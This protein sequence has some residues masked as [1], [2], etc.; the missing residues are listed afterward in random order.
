MRL[1]PQRRNRMA[2]RLKPASRVHYVRLRKACVRCDPPVSISLRVGVDAPDGAQGGARRPP[3]RECAPETDAFP[4]WRRG[5]L[6]VTP[7]GGCDDEAWQGLLRTD[8][9]HRSPARRSPVA[10]TLHG[11]TPQRWGS[12]RYFLA[13]QRSGMLPRLKA[14]CMEVRPQRWGSRRY[15]LARQRSG[16]LPRLKAPCMEVR[17]QRWGSRRYFLARQRS[18]MLPRLK[19]PDRSGERKRRKAGSCVATAGVPVRARRRVRS[20]LSAYANP[21]RRR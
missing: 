2:P 7:L 20:I 13:R 12:R 8:V 21:R 19:A 9:R 16:M 5:P 10:L 15:F 11:S 3:F 18:G 17:P 1:C 14:P 4:L 6:P